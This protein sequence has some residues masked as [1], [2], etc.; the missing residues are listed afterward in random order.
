VTACAGHA[1]APSRP[2]RAG[3]PARAR[4]VGAAWHDRAG[5]PR[6][7]WCF[8]GMGCCLG[9]CLAQFCSHSMVRRCVAHALSVSVLSML[10]DRVYCMNSWKIS[11]SSVKTCWSQ[12]HWSQ[13]SYTISSVSPCMRVCSACSD[14]PRCAVQPQPVHVTAPPTAAAPAS[15]LHAAARITAPPGSAG[16]SS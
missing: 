9:V 15:A 11:R 2:A 4:V 6:L 16:R 5:F 8:Q 3:P 10:V 1:A 12:R 13:V 7:L 14:I